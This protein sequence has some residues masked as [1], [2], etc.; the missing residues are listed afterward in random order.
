M[1]LA[2][3][4]AFT[5]PAFVLW[6]NAWSDGA[7]STVRCACLDPGQQ[8]WF[9]A[10][11]AYALAHGLNPFSTTWL[12][13]PEGANLLANASAPLAGL[14]LSPF[15]WA[16]GP[17]AAT[18]LALTLAPG[19]SAWG[20]WVACRRFVSWQPACWVAGF[21]FGYSPFVV[22]SVA[23]GHLSTGLLVFPPLIL[24]VLHE[25]LVRQQRSVAWCGVALAVLVS[26]QFLVSAEVLTITVVIVALGVVVVAALSP[27]RAVV[28]FPFAIRALAVACLVSVLLLAA[29]TWYM[30]AGP[31][32]IRGSV[33]SGEQGIFVALVWDLWNA[34]PY[35]ALTLF[36]G[37]PEGPPL[38]FLG[39]GV[40]V[41]AGVSVAL[42]WRRR[43]MWVMAILAVVCTVLSWG[44]IF[45]LSPDHLATSRWLPWY[46]L[47]NLPLLDN[48]SAIHIAA[49]ADL[50]VAAVVAIGLDALRLS[51]PWRRL[52]SA[53]RV[54]VVGGVAALMVVPVWW[55]YRAP[56]IVRRIALPQWYATAALEVPEGS[57]ITSYPFPASAS[58]KSQPMVWQAADEMRFRLS[59][60][61]IKVPG[62]GDGVIGTGPPGSAARTLIDLT[63][64]SGAAGEKFTLTA[65]QLEA[66]RSALRTWGTSYVVV[67]DTGAVPT[68][69]AGVF[70]AATG[71]LPQISHRAWV[72]DLRARPLRSPYDAAMAAR[73]FNTCRL[74]ATQ[75]GVAPSGRPLSQVLDQCVVAGARHV[76]GT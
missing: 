69:A 12:W 15:T 39:I 16:F 72:W 70:T 13:P 59:G 48:V 65:H 27:R 34:G 54:I 28:G 21:L 30:L 47:T 45:G 32:R 6:W 58:L 46:W 56:L 44:G 61:Y 7:A 62:R 42:A 24:V 18:T 64:G 33:W 38:E 25:I 74:L 49:F 43:S 10:W 50:A 60:G 35:R 52:P 40:L 8:V 67:T 14:L 2:V 4:G 71:M 76:A 53:C 41:V 36:P 29:P 3:A 66:L 17:F 5:V 26:A 37:T 68:E 51:R 73:S 11:P 55:T 22:Q 20:C 1:H 31:Q 63:L 23:Q 9:I 19:L 75:L 57:V